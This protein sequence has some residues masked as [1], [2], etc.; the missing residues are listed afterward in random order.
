MRL[1][2]DNVKQI[3]ELKEQGVSVRDIAQRLGV[4]QQAISYHLYPKY[5]EHTIERASEKAASIS[6]WR[7]IYFKCP[8]CNSENIEVR[9]LKNRYE[10]LDC[11]YIWR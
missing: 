3:F 8:K 6:G 4:S 11:E 9:L 10:C 1:S 7:M 5:R 2:D